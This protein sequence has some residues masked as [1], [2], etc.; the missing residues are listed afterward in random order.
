MQKSIH[1][2]MK[3]WL[4]IILCLSAH[5]LF[6]QMPKHIGNFPLFQQY[7]NPALTA[8][9]Y[10]A[11]K[12]FYRNQFTGFEDAPRSIFLS[13]ELDPS[14]LHLLTSKNRHVTELNYH[15]HRQRAGYHAMGMSLWYHSFGAFTETQINLNYSARVSLTKTLSLRA[16]GVV[17]YSGNRLDMDRL[18]FE[19]ADDPV[20]SKASQGFYNARRVD[21]N[22][23]VALTHEQFYIGYALQD[24][25]REGLYFG[26]DFLLGTVSRKHILQGG[27]RKPVSEEVSLIANGLFSYDKF[28]RA[29]FDVQAKSVFLKTFWTGVGYRQRS[30]YTVT[31]GFIMRKINLSYLL[32]IP[33]GRASTLPYL[34]HE[35]VLSFDL[36]QVQQDSWR[37]RREAITW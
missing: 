25:V 33:A 6:A 24:V 16:G 12:I 30:A 21:I 22:V 8:Y 10:S 2:Q 7:Y 23:G 31:A 27:I 9:D 26:D 37:Q 4:M 19:Q 32:E 13:G 29:S 28:Q 5:A 35:V 3:N 34:T 36:I 15:R 17:S 20:Y 1:F 11:M 14:D 18:S